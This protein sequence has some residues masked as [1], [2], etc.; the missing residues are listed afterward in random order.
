MNYERPID[1]FSDPELIWDP[2]SESRLPDSSLRDVVR[3]QAL[4]NSEFKRQRDR[5]ASLLLDMMWTGGFDGTFHQIHPG[6]QAFL[7]YS[8]EELRQMSLFDLTVPEDLPTVQGALRKLGED[9]E[10]GEFQIRC[11]AKDGTQRWLQCRAKAYQEESTYYAVARDVSDQIDTENRLL[12]NALHDPLTGL[13][14]RS[15]FLD[16]LQHTLERAKRQKGSHYSVLFIDLDRFKIV[17]D[18]LGHMVGDE[19]LVQIAKRLAFCVRNVDTISRLGGDEFAILLEDAHTAEDSLMVANRIQREIALPMNFGGTELF[20]TASIGITQ[21]SQGYERAEDVLRDA[22]T[23]MYRAKFSG[24][25]HNE[26]FQAD[27]HSEAMALMRLDTDLRLAITRQE[28]EPY[29]QPIV[30]FETGKIVG[31]EAL[32]RWTHPVRGTISPLE[33]IPVAE[34]TGLIAPIGRWVLFEAC[35]Q[36]A[37][38]QKDFPSNP[39]LYVS[40]NVSG[41]QFTQPDFL[42]QVETALGENHLDPRCLKL[43]ITETVILENENA[44]LPILNRLREMGIQ[45]YIDDFGTGYSSLNYLHR[46]PFDLLKIDR[47]FIMNLNTGTTNTE[48]VKTI[49]LLANNLGMGV[50][51]EGVEKIEQISFLKALSCQLGQ[52]YHFSRP[53]PRDKAEILLGKTG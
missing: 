26:I 12:H 21:G 41:R 47:S 50:I 52:G 9:N 6:S 29:Y 24:K 51:A 45:L 20:I 38:W 32:L 17:N 33:F 44:V 15:L 36:L 39:P 46:F 3:S 18:S 13:P 22:D 34:E 42:H 10:V 19:L 40:V 31:F 5:F 2:E 4:L 25:A 7:G 30:S 43:E 16:R 53:L 35:R 27:M 1:A 49:L 14:N 23:A 28:F 8:R 11:H 37:A 48:L